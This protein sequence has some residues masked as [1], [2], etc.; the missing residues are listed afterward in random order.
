MVDLEKIC[1]FCKQNVIL[2]LIS[3]CLTVKDS[4]PFPQV[5]DITRETDQTIM[6]F[7]LFPIFF[8]S[9]P[10]VHLQ[11]YNTDKKNLNNPPMDLIQRML[12]QSV[13]NTQSI[14]LDFLHLTGACACLGGMVIA[15]VV[16]MCLWS[17]IVGL[18]CV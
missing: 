16:L 13:S 8:F 15:C 18:Y 5:D 14:H 7:L 1:I 3:P 10:L 9:F 4:F 2:L 12:V 11:L 6:Q 17:C